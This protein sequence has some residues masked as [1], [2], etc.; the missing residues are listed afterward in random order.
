MKISLNWLKEFV[1]VSVDATALARKLTDVGL[2][3][4][5]IEEVAGDTVFELD[6][7]SNRPDCL[8]HLGVAREVSAFSGRPL[9]F[10]QFVVREADQA[11]AEVA[12]ISFADPVL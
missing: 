3:V 8:S 10:P 12:S 2:A 4:E 5:S 6:V 11:A 9:R 7:A 1:D